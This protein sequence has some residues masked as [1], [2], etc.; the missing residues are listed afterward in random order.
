[1]NDSAEKAGSNSL[2]RGFAVLR[3]LATAPEEGLRLKEIAHAAAMPQ[4]TVHRIL[5][6]L[7][8]EDMVEQTVNAKSYR[9]GLS[10]YSLAARA[11]GSYSRFREQCRPSLLRL[12]G[13]L[14][15]TVF[16]MVRSGL[17]LICLDRIEGPMPI[18]SLSG[19]VGGRIP[20]GLGQAGAI[21]LALLPE[22]ER[23][24]VI[25][26]NVPRLIHKGFLDEVT[27]R[28]NVE[29]ALTN[30][31]AVSQGKG[32]L[33]E[34]GGVSVGITDANNTVV[35]A[36]SIGALTERLNDERLPHIVGILR[37]EAEHIGRL[38]N[39]FDPALRR[40][41]QYLRTFDP[42]GNRPAQA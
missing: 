10:L 12:S 34:M 11:G 3:I 40:P 42:P 2:G 16:L 29:K 25:R 14:N 23:E 9:L 18:R 8:A 27:L 17:D 31:Y 19:D 7:E 6:T 38:I 37:K 1:M 33:P 39:P 13:V 35:G 24:E 5:K 30:R 22:D 32:L 26:F 21:I 4:A 20:L 28:V 36:L 41:A 15:E